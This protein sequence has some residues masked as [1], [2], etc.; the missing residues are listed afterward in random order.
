MKLAALIFVSLLVI[1]L[2]LAIACAIRKRAELAFAFFGL[3]AAIVG[4]FAFA[5]RA[6]PE[7]FAGRLFHYL[8]HFGAS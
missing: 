1:V 3:Y 8:L 2:A 6:H 4:G 7:S 5:A